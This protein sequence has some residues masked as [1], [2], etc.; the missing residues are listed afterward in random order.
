MS[1]QGWGLGLDSAKRVS[2]QY[3]P[4][5]DVHDIG[6]HMFMRTEMDNNSGVNLPSY[7]VFPPSASGNSMPGQRLQVNERSKQQIKMWQ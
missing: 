5:P 4:A 3:F 6:R 7:S 1:T 2:P